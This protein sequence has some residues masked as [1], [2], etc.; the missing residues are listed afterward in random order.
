MAF[1]VLRQPDWNRQIWINPHR[2]RWSGFLDPAD[3]HIAQAEDGR[4]D[5][6]QQEGVVADSEYQE[7]ERHEQGA[8]QIEHDLP[9]NDEAEVVPFGRQIIGVGRPWHLQDIAG[10]VLVGID[11]DH[12]AEVV[13]KDPPDP[14][15]KIK[16]VDQPDEL[17]FVLLVGQPT[18]EIK[19]EKSDSG[20][21]GIDGADSGRALEQEKDEQRPDDEADP[22]L[23]GVTAVT[24]KERPIGRTKHLAP[25]TLGLED[26]RL[27][28]FLIGQQQNRNRRDDHQGDGQSEEDA[29]AGKANDQA[30]K[31]GRQQASQEGRTEQSADLP[32]ALLGIGMF[33]EIQMVAQGA[34]LSLQDI[35]RRQDENQPARTGQELQ[36]CEK[37]DL[38]K[39]G[40]EDRFLDADLD[41][42]RRHEVAGQDDGVDWQK[43]I[44]EQDLHDRIVELIEIDRHEDR[45]QAEGEVD[46][47]EREIDL[48]H[49][50]VF[51]KMPEMLLM[52]SLKHGVFA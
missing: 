23:D 27:D 8:R 18:D 14:A 11:K 49:L 28:G 33:E 24:D 40:K 9:L 19:N 16:E 39:N 22:L 43:E 38:E 45:D 34:D 1:S 31:Q 41:D 42:Q 48:V 51:Q 17:F 44:I 36:T 12:G 15:E 7:D 47:A 21:D 20:H 52:M 26:D 5:E 25:H 6:G 4:H 30:A 50:F 10:N 13:G 2:C 46:D 3:S 29:E 32:A 37:D 35:E